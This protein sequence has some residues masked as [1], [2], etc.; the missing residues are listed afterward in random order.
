MAEESP[1]GGWR[2]RVYRVIFEHAT[3]AGRAFDLVLLVLILASV[4][5]VLLESVPLLRVRWGAELLAVEWAFTILFSIEYVLR[6]LS[7]RRPLAYARSFFGLIDLVAVLPTYLSLLLPG[8]QVLLILRAVRLLRVFRILK[9]G[10]FLGEEL[11]L[12]RALR[13]SIR[14]IVIF[15]GAVLVLVLV[16]GS[17]MYLV[18]GP[19]GG[20]TSIPMSIYWAIVTM[21]TVGYGDL[22][23]QTVLGRMLASLVM[24]IGYGIIAV[25]TGIVTVEMGLAS[26]RA[27]AHRCPACGLT[28]HDDDA[29][30]CKR[31]GE[32]LPAA[33]G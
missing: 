22:V 32:R 28:G 5:A 4:V 3:P 2:E 9:L 33:A 8:S 15:I 17:L 26:R 27:A 18:E 10:R 11:V 12:I 19:Q 16:L 6:L 30:H 29:A 13:A 20:F 14:K 23:P 21:T 31:C 7:V 1:E 25:P 24:M